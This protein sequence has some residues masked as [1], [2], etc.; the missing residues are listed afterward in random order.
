MEFFLPISYL[1]DFVFCPYSIYLLQV[2]DNSKEEVYSANP[3]QKGKS[4][5]DIVDN[6]NL[7]KSKK[8][9][10]GTDVLNFYYCR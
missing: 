5:H 1:N 7:K 8:I 3:Q 2:F 4:A 9:L 10:S 6:T